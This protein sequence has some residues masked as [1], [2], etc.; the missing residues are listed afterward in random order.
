VVLFGVKVVRLV[1]VKP[2][3]MAS[4]LNE[5]RLGGGETRHNHPYH[6]DHTAREIVHPSKPRVIPAPQA[7]F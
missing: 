6:F 5:R 4:L 7:I 3:V 1:D 2:P